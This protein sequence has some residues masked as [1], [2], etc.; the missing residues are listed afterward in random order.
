MGEVKINYCDL[1]NINLTIS[2]YIIILWWILK[3]VYMFDTKL[4]MLLKHDFHKA[5]LK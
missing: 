5:I 2:R 3:I 4:D 1:K